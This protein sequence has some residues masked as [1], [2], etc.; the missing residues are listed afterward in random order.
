M[1]NVILKTFSEMEWSMGKKSMGYFPLTCRY[2][3]DDLIFSQRIFSSFC[4]KNMQKVGAV[5]CKCLLENY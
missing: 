3:Y 4:R 1:K 5:K 2:W